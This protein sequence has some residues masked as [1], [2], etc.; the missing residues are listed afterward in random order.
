MADEAI[1]ES[2]QCQVGSLNPG[3]RDQWFWGQAEPP[4]PASSP[5][6]TSSPPSWWQQRAAAHDL[7]HAQ[8]QG[9]HNLL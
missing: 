3:V 4:A 1:T 5:A 2:E 8:K 7:K 6:T 9:Q